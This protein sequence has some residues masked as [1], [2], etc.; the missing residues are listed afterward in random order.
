MTKPRL[1]LPVLAIASSLALLAGCGGSSSSSSGTDVAGLAPP[2]S[3]LFIEATIKPTGSMKADV[4]ALAQKIAGVENLGDE[5]VSKLED[6]ARESGEPFNYEKEVAPWIGETAGVSFQE[7]DGS[8]F[9]GYAVVVPTSDAEA[10]QE[11]VEKQSGSKGEPPKKG[12]YEGVEYEI[13]PENGSTAGVVGEFLVV[14]KSVATFKEAVDASN[15]ESLADTAEYGKAIATAPGGSI[16]NAYVDVGALIEQGG[17][18]VSGQAEQIFKSAGIDPRKATALASLVP[19]SDQV[20]ID[21]SSTLAGKNAS[22][23][24][25]SQLLGSLPAHSFAAF[26]SPEFGK[27]LE[28]VVDT[29]DEKGLP[30]KLPPHKLK[31]LV[32]E[33]GF[34]LD[35]IAGSFQD[36]GVFAEGTSK[37]SLGGAAVLTTTG[38]SEAS[39][40]IAGLGLLL[41]ASHTPGI[42][43][44]SGKASGF[45]VRSAELGPKPLVVAT[46]G[47]RIAIGYGLPATYEALSAESGATLSESPVYKEAVAALGGEP[48]SGF[49]DGPATLRLVDA[50]VPGGEQGY[51]EARPYLAQAGYIAIGSSVQGELATAKLILGLKK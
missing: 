7:F 26:A 51:K 6:S 3:P 44:I 45:S 34:D 29:I 9:S 13:E 32:S 42:T 50:L 43:A 8:N 15:G 38:S 37:S 23:G 27:R 20:E 30:G 28:E 16:A 17:S 39:K 48:I 1:L 4:D 25:A 41:R 21:V 12:S 46:E 18:E 35:K 24:D 47:D 11:F 40:A 36:L 2:E 10:T 5:I 33:A 19:G 14:A 49:V 31:S 22:S